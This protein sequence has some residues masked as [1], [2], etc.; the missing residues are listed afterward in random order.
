M[1]NNS[2]RVERGGGG[3]GINNNNKFT[4]DHHPHQRV[5]N[6]VDSLQMSAFDN[7]NNEASLHDSAMGDN[8][9]NI[10]NSIIS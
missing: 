6:K 3:G 2:Q 5:D 10:N 4:E 9:N 8:T 1:Y 7:T